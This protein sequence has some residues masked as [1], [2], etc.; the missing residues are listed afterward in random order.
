MSVVIVSE[1]CLKMKTYLVIVCATVMWCAARTTSETASV[2]YTYN[3]SDIS[4]LSNGIQFPVAESEVQPL[5]GPDA[6]RNISEMLWLSGLYDHFKWWTHL[7]GL[8]NERCRKDM[9]IYLRELS[10][11]TSWATKSQ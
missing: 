4:Y 9:M 7:N 8:D 3:S 1:Q 6:P 5:L 2:T 11:A 10:N